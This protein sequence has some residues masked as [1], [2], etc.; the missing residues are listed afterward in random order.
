MPD[1]R[2][3]RRRSI[4]GH[5]YLIVLMLVLATSLPI[6]LLWLSVSS[7]SNSLPSFKHVRGSFS[8]SEAIL[9]DRHYQVLH[10]FRI[11]PAGRRLQWVELG[12]ISPAL[13]SAVIFA[14]DKR[15]SQ[16]QGIDWKAMA[17]ALKSLLSSRYERGASTITMQLASKLLPELQPKTSHHSLRQKCKQI[18]AAWIL[19]RSWS[20][21]EILEAYLNLVTF[22]GELQ[23]IATASKGLFDKKPH[24]LDSSESVILASLLRSPSAS[25]DQVASRACEL[26]ESLSLHL[27]CS[28]LVST[29][30]KALSLPYTIQPE[31]ALAPHVA[32]RLLEPRRGQVRGSLTQMVCTL[33]QKLQRFATESLQQ[34]LLSVQGQNVHDG[35]ILVADNKTGEILA[36][37]G[38][39]GALASARYVDG[40]Q[41]RRQAGS[42]L[43][44]FLY[45]LAFDKLLVT[46]AS[47]LDDAP[48]DIPAANGIYRPENYDKQFHGLVTARTALASSLNIPAVKLLNLTGVDLFV[49]KL[50]DFGFER[51]QSP[52]FYGPSLALGSA[53]VT[54]WE[55][56]N[57][58]RTLANSGV[59]SPLRLTFD[60]EAKFSRRQ[61]LS[62]GSAFILSDILSDRESRSETFHLESPLA[63]RF[64]T[65]VKTGTSKDMR[66]NWCVGFS[67][68]YTVGVWAGN[69]SGQ[70]MWNVSGITGA[71]PVWTELMT[72]LHHHLH[73]KAPVPPPE[74]VA[75]RIELSGLGYDRTEWFLK[76]TETLMVKAAS[77]QSNF[78]IVYPTS[79]TII[80]LDPEIP[81][82]QQKLFFECQP[83]G[84][85]LQWRLDGE[86]AGPA[87][88]LLLWS[89]QRGQHTLAL[90]DE[91][92][93]VLDSVSFE[94]RGN[95]NVSS[96]TLRSSF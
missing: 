26:S 60:E 10:E 40:V 44:P 11:D 43:K 68:H 86:S 62:A 47:L 51:L 52:D 16:H 42:I 58:Y 36:Y 31:I 4:R 53:D 81:E 75:R 71:A 72:W 27:N 82:D 56:V 90:I 59:W 34:H 8:R 21:A 12:E 41:A 25:P 46:P 1:C 64:W 69:F 28:A 20:K 30:Q 32:W 7:C 61:A 54:L 76:G 33:D 19:E 48:L 38:N 49:Q 78:R 22:R 94:V 15:F 57:A 87:G 88:S 74:V 35:A 63:T 3:P 73:S 6:G 65:A 50:E 14:E 84:N 79:G 24:G 95:L 17:G 66:D 2:N 13:T 92:G 89:P 5:F 70:P 23:G 18:Q 93:R 83:R 37:V 39:V 29:T 96:S 67:D 85:K 91:T 9:L 80:A 45:G 55:L 77:D